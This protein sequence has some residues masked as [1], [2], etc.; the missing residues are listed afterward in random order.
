MW[1]IGCDIADVTFDV[2][3]ISEPDHIE[4]TLFHLP[5]A[6][7]GFC[8]MAAHLKQCGMVPGNAIMIMECTGVYSE[9]V[10][11]YFYH[12]GFAVYVEPPQQVKK[13]FTDKRKTDPVDSRQVAEY[14]FRFRDKLH[15]WQPADEIIDAVRALLALREQLIRAR[16]ASKNALKAL[17][18]KQHQHAPILAR[19]HNVIDYLDS[20]VQDVEHEIDSQLRTNPGLYAQT[21]NLTTLP[22]VGFLLA[23]SLA[24]LTNG[25]TEHVDARE[26]ASFL[27]LCP[28][29]YQSGTS[30]YRP[31]SSDG[32][33][34][35]RLRKL[36][37]L[38]AM[39]ARAHYPS[40]R[41]YFDRKVAEGKPKQLVLNN[42]A[43]KLVHILCAMM[44]SG[45]PYLKNYRSGDPRNL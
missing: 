30:V 21:Q 33:G 45:K 24:V 31:A 10:S 11:H 28:W 32:A 16:T 36:L 12:Q 6:E 25:F 22:C 14:G 26:I 42:I 35:G 3:V 44:H 38:A 17:T 18:R 4:T 40:M 27:G 34:P 23:V 37:Y 15:P 7:P 41:T 20:S 8:Q 29:P 13:A 2:T 1:Y 39:S 19:Y 43:N 9:R 5:N